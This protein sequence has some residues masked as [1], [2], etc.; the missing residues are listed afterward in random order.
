MTKKQLIPWGTNIL[1][2]E[3]PKVSQRGRILIPEAH[4][5]KLNQ[6]KVV[7]K[8]PLCSENIVVGDILFFPF[9]SEHR[10]SL[11][12][13]DV[14]KDDYLFIVVPE[15]AVLGCIKTHESAS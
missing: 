14:E 13:P 4:Q 10:L 1:L 5:V 8:G 3:L 2:E 15:E 11:A 9:H 7:D 12:N 6:G